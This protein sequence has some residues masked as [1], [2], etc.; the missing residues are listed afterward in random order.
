MIG[1]E[2]K[3][4]RKTTGSDAVNECIGVIP[5]TNEQKYN[6]RIILKPFRG[7]KKCFKLVSAAEISRVSDNEFIFELPLFAQWI[8]GNFDRYNLFVIASVVN[9]GYAV[10]GNP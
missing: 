6:V 8:V 3:S 1:Q 4:I 2:T 10:Q 7:T 9:N 5:G